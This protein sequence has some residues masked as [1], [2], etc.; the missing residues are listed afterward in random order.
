MA[1]Q[2]SH[3]AMPCKL[4]LCSLWKSCS[5][6][7]DILVSKDRTCIGLLGFHYMSAQQLWQLLAGSSHIQINQKVGGRSASIGQMTFCLWKACSTQW[8][9]GWRYLH[10]YCPGKSNSNG[11][12][13]RCPCRM[14]MQWMQ[15]LLRSLVYPAHSV[16][17]CWNSSINLSIELL[18]LVPSKLSGLPAADR[19]ACSFH[20]IWQSLKHRWVFLYSRRSKLGCCNQLCCGSLLLWCAVALCCAVLCCSALCISLVCAHLGKCGRRPLF[21][22]LLSW[23]SLLGAIAESSANSW[24][25][26]FRLSYCGLWPS[27]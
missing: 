6:A 13:L 11:T 25:Q 14:W 7:L 17:D 20:S 21:P 10:P 1:Q 2:V 24:A 15:T 3:T 16:P 12:A 18:H 22:F 4:S 26:Q 9:T 19:I 5:H 23:T 8:Q 27:C